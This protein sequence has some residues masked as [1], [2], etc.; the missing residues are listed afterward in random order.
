MTQITAPTARLE[1]RRDVDGSVH[2]SYSIPVLTK[3]KGNRWFATCPLL[4][5]L[6]TSPKSKEDAIKDHWTDVDTFLSLHLKTKTL[7]RAL[8]S[9]GWHKSAD[10]KAF[11]VIPSIPYEL[12]PTIHHEERSVQVGAAA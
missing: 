8:K 9:L 11:E 2:V 10:H 7:D 12:F 1:I 5:S 6:G 4:K 3:Q